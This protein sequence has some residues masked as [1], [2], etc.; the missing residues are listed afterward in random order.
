MQG[1]RV[2]VNLGIIRIRNTKL[3]KIFRREYGREGE[4]EREEGGDLGGVIMIYNM[5]EKYYN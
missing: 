5:V 4:R 1:C 3:E 2:C